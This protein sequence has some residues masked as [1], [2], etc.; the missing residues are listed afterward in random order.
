MVCSW[1]SPQFR[2]K[3]YPDQSPDAAGDRQVPR[4]SLPRHGVTSS[5]VASYHYF[6]GHYPSVFAHIGSCDKP[7]ASYLISASRLIQASPCRL[8]SAPAGR[9]FLPT[10]SL[11]S[12]L[13][14]NAP[15]PRCLPWCSRLFLPIGHRPS[16]RSRI[17]SAIHNDPHTSNFGAGSNFAVLGDSITTFTVNLFIPPDLFATLI[18]PTA[19]VLCPTGQLW[20]LHP[21]RTCVVTSTCIGYASR[22]NT[23][24]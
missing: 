22:P 7:P 24:N 17:G 19:A 23:D 18:A 14:M 20:R 12:F 9:W 21:S 6:V 13:W 3:T 16:P 8:L 11:H 15:V 5:G 2:S 10:L 4:A 1:V